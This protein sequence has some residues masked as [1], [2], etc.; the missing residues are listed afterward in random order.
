MCRWGAQCNAQT[1][2]CSTDSLS[3]PSPSIL[4][5]AGVSWGEWALGW[6]LGFMQPYPHSSQLERLPRTIPP[7]NTEK[8]STVKSRIFTYGRVCHPLFTPMFLLS[9]SHWISCETCNRIDLLQGTLGGCIYYPHMHDL[10]QHAPSQWL[11]MCCWFYRQ[12]KWG[13]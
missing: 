6:S 4:R 3:D 1:N 12:V 13:K 11:T 7:I 10:I 8:S 5:A 2:S 9:V